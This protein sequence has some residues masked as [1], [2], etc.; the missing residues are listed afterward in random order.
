MAAILVVA[1]GVSP[2]RAQSI[3]LVSAG[4]QYMPSAKLGGQ[5]GEA[6]V[7]SYD[8]AVNAP[9]PLAEKTFIIPGLGYH[10]DSVSY[11][12]AGPGFV[13][14]RAF[15]SVEASAL[16]VQMLPKD[17]TIAARVATGLAGDFREVDAGLLRASAVAT[18]TH[19]F[20]KRFVLGGGAI[21]SFG[22]GQFLPLPAL[23]LD[24]KPADGFEV[25]TFLPAF[26]RVHY[27]LM[28]RLRFGV[29]ADFSGNQ[30]AVRDSRLPGFDNLAYSVGTA[31]LIVGIRLFS[32]VWLTG[33][34]GHSFFRRLDRRDASRELLPGGSDDL[35]N[36]PVIR[37]GIVWK[38]PDRD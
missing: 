35:P 2:A 22:F 23:F 24:W 37:A 21:T 31:G 14:L 3:D 36:V 32:S 10:A 25:E 12:G 33:L 11:S 38:V 18:A 29:A 19:A 15:Q 16:V 26:V 5:P 20:S 9:I 28:G 4:A 13:Q 7:A 17:W 34:A 6:Q 27:T 8:V 1:A 30:Y